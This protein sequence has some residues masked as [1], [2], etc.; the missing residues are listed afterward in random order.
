MGVASLIPGVKLPDNWDIAPTQQQLDAVIIE[1]WDDLKIKL[2][3]MFTKEEK[4]GTKWARAG[5]QH[6]K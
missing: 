1:G 6:G 4:P 2:I 3:K 5:M